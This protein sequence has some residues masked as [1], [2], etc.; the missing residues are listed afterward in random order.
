MEFS[1]MLRNWCFE[2]FLARSI[3]SAVNF[4]SMVKLVYIYIYILKSAYLG[5]KLLLSFIKDDG[6]MFFILNGNFS[7]FVI[8]LLSGYRYI[9]IYIYIYIYSIIY[10]I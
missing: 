2:L 1:V 3:Q 4:D 7:S 5:S 8:F 6:A 10:L 9:Y